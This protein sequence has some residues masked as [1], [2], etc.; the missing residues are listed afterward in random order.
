MA[1]KTI[2]TEGDVVKA[3]DELKK[4][5]NKFSEDSD[6]QSRRLFRLTMTIAFLTVVMV[7]VIFV[8]IMIMPHDLDWVND[9][10]AG[11][12]NIARVLRSQSHDPIQLVRDR[13]KAIRSIG[14][15]DRHSLCDP[16]EDATL[17][18]RH[19]LYQSTGLF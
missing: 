11:I 6:R 1:D 14:S 18:V 9:I 5:V 15:S 16:L 12:E 8:Q 3:V 10:Q 17:L 13:P 19:R 4:A 2:F 7:F